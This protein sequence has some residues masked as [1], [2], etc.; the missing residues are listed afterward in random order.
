MRKVQK[1]IIPVTDRLQQTAG[2][3]EREWKMHIVHCN[4]ETILVDLS[5]MVIE[6]FI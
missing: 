4:V 1:D 6:E 5:S 2:K 3:Q